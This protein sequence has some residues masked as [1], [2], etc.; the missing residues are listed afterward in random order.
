MLQLTLS[1]VDPSS[2]SAKYF[3]RLLNLYSDALSSLILHLVFL[4]ASHT[5]NWRNHYN[6]HHDNRPHACKKCNKIFKSKTILT[7]HLKDV[8]NESDGRNVSHTC[9]VCGADFNRYP[10]LAYKRRIVFLL[11]S[12]LNS[13]TQIL[14]Y[15]NL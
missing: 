11:Y 6:S 14:I 10:L 3:E 9:F 8:H 4:Q 13:F 5:G 1:S 15:L 12:R 2:N 7:Q